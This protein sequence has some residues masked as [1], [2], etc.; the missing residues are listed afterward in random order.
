MPDLPAV[1]SQP[2]PEVIATGIGDLAC[3][4]LLEYAREGLAVWQPVADPPGA[5]F[6]IWNRR[7]AEITGHTREAIN[8]LGLC[9]ALRPEKTGLE[10]SQERL[11]RVRHGEHLAAEVWEITR[12]DGGRRSLRLTTQALAGTDLVLL[13]AEDIT[14]QETA[15]AALAASEAR[16]RT[17]FHTSPDAISV[18]RFADGVY[19]DV[20]DAFL[21]IT[22]FSREEVIGSSSLMIDI[23][24]DLADRRQLMEALNEYGFVRNQEARF[25]M[26]D[27]TVRL[28]LL[29]ARVIDIDGVLHI[30]SMTRDITELR[31]VERQRQEIE[32]QYRLLVESAIDAIVIAQDGCLVFANPR[33]VE[34][35]GRSAAE[36]A[37]MPFEVMIH[38]ADRAMV[39]DRHH[40]RLAGEEQPE[41]YSFR[42]VTP[43]G[44]EVWVQVSCRVITW[45]GRPAV[46]SFLRDISE[47]RRME[48]QLRQAA[49]MEAIG[50]LAAGVAHDFNNLLT[51][52]QGHAALMRWRVTPDHPFHESLATIEAV[53]KSAASLTRQLLGLA[54]GG[55]YE[56]RRQDLNAIVRDSSRLFGRTRKELTVTTSLAPDLWPVEVDRHQMEQVLLNLFLNAWQAMPAG[57]RLTLTTANRLLD[58]G[59]VSLLG[60]PPGRYIELAVTDTGI[61]MDEATRQRVFD[62]FFT[63]REKERGTGLGLA[64]AYA[65][66]TNHG[67]LISVDSQPGQ[68]TTFRI[69]LPAAKEARPEPVPPH[70]CR[71]RGGET[72]LLVDDE[73]LVAGV[74]SQM[75]AALG[76]HVLVAGSGPEAL[77]LLR[78]EGSGIGL[79]ILDMLMPG[80]NG[81]ATY[82]RLREIDPR[83]PVLV[84][85][86]FSKDA[87]A[88]ALMAQGCRGFIQKPY[89]LDALA[90]K[91][92]EVLAG[93]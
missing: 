28:G 80:M 81:A 59:A 15:L 79:V 17:M 37:H 90:T 85:S 70:H 5:R 14:D 8:E 77:D 54:R 38:P 27:G 34:L 35:T 1:P 4:A 53:V 42:I 55:K 46:L 11:Q 50:S 31:G 29:S 65:I 20:N 9:Q 71:P 23:W 83:V 87:E 21:E 66:I 13:M 19:Q 57:G 26:K 86:G 73:S 82:S 51:A 78:K 93:G 22:G 88:E 48:A 92:R 18:T 32:E 6:L 64:S 63:T 60:R 61:G 69:L 49:T 74:A 44:Q 10:R 16:L 45:Q 91:V 7:L 47:Q 72:V 36:L 75:L 43:P 52:I 76:Y 56:V 24:Q 84:A 30:L 41:V 68:G 39:M 89:G 3:Q 40:R 67:G 33:T 62:P 12:A 25:R 58:E 2:S